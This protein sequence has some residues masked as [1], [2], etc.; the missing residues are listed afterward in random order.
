[1]GK[2]W[3]LT[4]FFISAHC[5]KHYHI[6]CLKVL[7]PQASYNSHK[8]SF[9]NL[10]CPQHVCHTC[11]SDN[12]RGDR[13]RFAHEKLVRCIRCPTSYHYGTFITSVKQYWVLLPLNS[14]VNNFIFIFPGNY[15]VPAGSE[16]LTATQMIC[17]RHYEPPKKG[18][19][20]IN[21]SWCFICSIGMSL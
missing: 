2:Y 20:H 15:C 5:G 14:F 11:V 8:G 7:W 1:M 19:H 16:I 12:P 17:P 21:A 10:S 6:E 18:I 4:I 13:G 9:Q 3:I